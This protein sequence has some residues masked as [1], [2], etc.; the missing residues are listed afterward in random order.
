M[1]KENVI[2]KCVLDDEVFYDKEEVIWISE[3]IVIKKDVDSGITIDKVAK[4]SK[5][6]LVFIEE[7]FHIS[8]N[9]KVVDLFD[10]NEL[11]GLSAFGLLKKLT[12]LSLSCDAS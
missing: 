5:G 1:I 4:T 6:H 10:I 12:S 7:I 8:I 11:A 9:E 2:Y 3:D